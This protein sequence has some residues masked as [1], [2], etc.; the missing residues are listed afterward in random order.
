MDVFF[1]KSSEFLRF[2]FRF[3]F[4]L[5][6]SLYW[7]R[8]G[9]VGDSTWRTILLISVF[10]PQQTAWS[11]PNNLSMNFCAQWTLTAALSRQQVTGSFVTLAN[12][13]PARFSHTF[14]EITQRKRIHLVNRIADVDKNLHLQK[15]RRQQSSPYANSQLHFN[16]IAWFRDLSC[17]VE[18]TV[19]A[20]FL[21][22][23]QRGWKWESVTP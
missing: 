12:N 7:R 8:C 4:S 15:R 19:F 17:F 23:T 11:T 9:C 18:H 14:N 16:W 22:L 6:Q 21:Q 5:S 1:R 20:F 2:S 10:F 3:C 13:F